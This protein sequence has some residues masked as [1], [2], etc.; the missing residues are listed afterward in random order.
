MHGDSRVIGYHPV[1]L[2]PV[3][4]SESAYSGPYADPQPEIRPS[5]PPPL[6]RPFRVERRPLTPKR[7]LPVQSNFFA[8]ISNPNTRAESTGF[9]KS[10]FGA[11]FH[12]EAA[13]TQPKRRR[14][15][16]NSLERIRAPS[17]TAQNG[18]NRERKRCWDANVPCS[19]TETLK[20]GRFQS[21]PP[22]TTQTA[23]LKRAPTEAP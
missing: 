13:E 11:A 22:E 18:K 9:E 5:A 10:Q 2:R 8:V 3:S 23:H 19:K 6:E 12:S 15:P 1:I 16:P 7:G 20:I 17:N 21:H 4:A 14:P